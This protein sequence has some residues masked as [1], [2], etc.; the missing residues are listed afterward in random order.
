MKWA[1]MMFSAGRVF[2]EVV[3]AQNEVEARSTAQARNPFA[4]F[5]SLTRVFD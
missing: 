5:I 2:T 4:R 1:V 3:I